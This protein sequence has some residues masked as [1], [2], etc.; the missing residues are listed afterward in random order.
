MEGGSGS[1]GGCQLTWLQVLENFKDV[2]SESFVD[3]FTEVI[4]WAAGFDDY[5]FETPA[6]LYENL[7]EIPFEFALIDAGG[8][9]VNRQTS[10]RD[11]DSY[12]AEGRGSLKVKSFLNLG[13]DAILL[14]PCHS[15]GVREQVYGSLSTF[16]TKAPE[17][18]IRNLWRLAGEIALQKLEKHP[19]RPFWMSTDGRGVPWLHLR[20]DIAPKYYKHRSYAVKPSLAAVSPVPVVTNDS[21]KPHVQ[22]QVNRSSKDEEYPT[23][24]HLSRSKSAPLTDNDN[25]VLSHG[26]PGNSEYGHTSSARS[27]TVQHNGPGT[28][29]NEYQA[30]TASAEGQ[31]S[32]HQTGL[33][34]QVPA[35]K[36]GSSNGSV[37]HSPSRHYMNT[38]DVPRH[39]GQHY[40][41][42]SH[43][44]RAGADGRSSYHLNQASGYAGA[45]DSSTVCT[46]DIYAAATSASKQPMR[47]HGRNGVTGYS[48]APQMADAS[49]LHSGPRQYASS[50]G[51]PTPQ[52]HHH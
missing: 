17:D 14:A 13:N 43:H 22:H 25:N 42:P 31:R 33:S 2:D 29:Y 34:H 30:G 41:Q 6:M 27:P 24:M 7:D 1:P 8:T 19:T 12:I 11:F 48:G 51:Y 16:L 50:R 20:I 44:Q 5:Y 47:D 45:Q 40:N 23:G 4:R 28:D 15:F 37:A 21:N 10:S 46:K 52:Y 35:N 18:Q 39:H 9:L 26:Y 49:S 38:T 3:F 36:Y 32:S